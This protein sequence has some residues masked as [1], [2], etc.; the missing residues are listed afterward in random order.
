MTAAIFNTDFVA[1]YLALGHG[2]TYFYGYEPDVLLR[3]QNCPT[4]GNLMLFLS[5]AEHHIRY[6]LATFHAAQM[7]MHDWLAAEGAHVM[8]PVAGGNI[9]L[10]AFA[11]DRPDGWHSLL[12]INKDEHAATHVAIDG[13][14]GPF[15]EAQ[16]S[17]RD[18]IWKAAGEQ[19]HPI[20]DLPPHHTSVPSAPADGFELPPYSITVITWQ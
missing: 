17:S 4:F 16:F 18:Y 19:G 5:D 1:H 2:A 11:L 14:T 12:V 9:A 10:T 15:R 20:R 6:P 8:H 3:E 13:V 7:V